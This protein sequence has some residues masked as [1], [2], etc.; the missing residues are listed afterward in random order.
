MHPAFL[1]DLLMQ[2]GAY[3]S[4][5]T[6]ELAIHLISVP[7][8]LRPAFRHIYISGKPLAPRLQLFNN[9]KFVHVA[10][11]PLGTSVYLH[12]ILWINVYV[13]WLALE[14]NH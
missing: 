11:C 5:V 2:S 13:Q 6:W 4:L 10:M 8:A 7:L 3:I 12:V 9:I 1:F 14:A